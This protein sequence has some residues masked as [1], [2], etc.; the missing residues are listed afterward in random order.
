MLRSDVAG[1]S[2]EYV[3]YFYFRHR[4]V[5]CI[6]CTHE[7]GKKR[8]RILCKKSDDSKTFVLHNGNMPGVQHAFNAECFVFVVYAVFGYCVG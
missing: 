3:D 6:F 1:A 4:L 5:Q 2:P 7:N 8:E